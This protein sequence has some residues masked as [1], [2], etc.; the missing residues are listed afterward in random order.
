MHKIRNKLI[1]CKES[2]YCP[3]RPYKQDDCIDALAS[4]INHPDAKPPYTQA[5]Q[6]PYRTAHRR[7]WR[8]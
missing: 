8:I 2:R 1:A 4:C 7:T 5:P 6:T 3:D